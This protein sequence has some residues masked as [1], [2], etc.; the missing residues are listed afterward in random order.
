MYVCVCVCVGGWGFKVGAPR[1]I[2][3]LYKGLDRLTLVQFTYTQCSHERE[4]LI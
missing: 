4:A 3:L 1:F 2:N